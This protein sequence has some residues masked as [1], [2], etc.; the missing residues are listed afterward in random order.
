MQADARRIRALSTAP[1]RA[2][3]R[4]R[5]NE[6]LLAQI[7]TALRRAGLPLDRWQDSVPQPAQQLANTQYRKLTTRLYFQNVR[8]EEVVA[9]A[10]HLVAADASLSISSIR[11]TAPGQP[12]NTD[13]HVDLSVTY[14]I[15][16]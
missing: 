1:K 5:A 3:E 2:A 12:G 6:E 14:L 10:H 7:E 15:Y 4:R 11:L 9:F 8:L 13:W 16:W